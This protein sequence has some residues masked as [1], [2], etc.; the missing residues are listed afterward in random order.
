MYVPDEDALEIVKQ[1]AITGQPAQEHPATVSVET[2]KRAKLRERRGRWRP[3]E[4][5]WQW[6]LWRGW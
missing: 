5:S 2:A 1:G 6:E 3:T 4:M